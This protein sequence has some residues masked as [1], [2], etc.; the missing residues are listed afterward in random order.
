MLYA[1][2]SHAISIPIII[3]FTRLKDE[4]GKPTAYTRLNSNGSAFRPRSMERGLLA[5]GIRRHHRRRVTSLHEIIEGRALD[6]DD[7]SNVLLI[8]T[9]CNFKITA[10]PKMSSF[11]NRAASI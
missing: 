4:H 8:L 1:F 6:F 5:G 10:R 11:P 3:K 9:T 7:V 2:R